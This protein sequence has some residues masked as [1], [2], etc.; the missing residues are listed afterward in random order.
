MT[1]QTVT[2]ESICEEQPKMS[3][4]LLQKQT[5][6]SSTIRSL[7]KISDI[8]S[9]PYTSIDKFDLRFIIFLN[10]AGKR[11]RLQVPQETQ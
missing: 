2:L 7:P 1:S 9:H 6:L 4:V 10:E 3:T 8:V 11:D 5:I